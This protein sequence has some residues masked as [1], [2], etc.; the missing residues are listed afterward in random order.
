MESRHLTITCARCGRAAA[1]V[2]LL[3]ATPEGEGMWHD[4]DRLER[5]DFL[6]EVIKFGEYAGLLK[7]FELLARADYAAARAEDPDFIGFFC[8]DCQKVYCQACWQIGPPEFDEGFYDCTRG[9]CPQGHEQI[10]DD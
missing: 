10:V 9:A 3:P 8:D 7:L 5:T 4:R 2:A 6:G 1:E